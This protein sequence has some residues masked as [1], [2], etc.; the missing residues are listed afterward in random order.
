MDCAWKGLSS[1]RVPGGEAWEEIFHFERQENFPIE[2]VSWID[3]VH[4]EM[5]GDGF[6]FFKR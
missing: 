1:F 4:W 3:A 5:L 2:F 6:P